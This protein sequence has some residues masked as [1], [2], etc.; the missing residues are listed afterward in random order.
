LEIWK[1]IAGYEGLYQ[2]SSFGR[3]RR[4]KKWIGN[5]HKRG[6]KDSISYLTPTDNGNGYLIVGLSKNKK[7]KNYYLHRLVAEAF[8]PNPENKFIVNHI[9]YNKRN[10]NI[11]NLEWL[12]QKDNVKHSVNNM[13]HPKGITHSNTGEKYISYRASKRLYR[14]TINKKEYGSCKTLEEAIL[15]RDS[16]LKKGV[17][18]SGKVNY[19]G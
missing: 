1:D 5:K 7:R 6:Y 9:D 2:V 11:N 4:L 13:K 14:I 3:V 15:K 16:I 19:A 17:V 8:I 10:N 12:S 18:K